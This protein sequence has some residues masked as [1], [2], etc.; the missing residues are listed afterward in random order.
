[1]LNEFESKRIKFGPA[2]AFL[3]QFGYGEVSMALIKRVLA[4][5]QCEVFT[6]L[7]YKDMNRWITDPNKAAAFSRAFGGNEW[8][9]CISLPEKQRREKL[10]QLYK[11]ALK[12]KGRAKY[13]VSFLMFD[14]NDAPLYW[15]LFCTN[16]LRGI[17]EMKKGMWKVDESG[18]FR[19]SDHD[20]PS[21]LMLLEKR[22]DQKW[23]AE[24]LK[25][26]LSG[27]TM[28]GE[29]IREFVLIETPCYLFK[30]ALKSLESSGIAKVVKEPTGR[31]PGT[32]ESLDGITL[33]FENQLFAFAE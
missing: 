30:A 16:S 2:L 27:Q 25:G 17:E 21:Q 8:N 28:N 11:D 23:L 7:D 24:E 20:D 6:Y 9:E 13:V 5:P 22:F 19:F 1:M 4:F 26:K 12:N 32:Y 15:L 29:K 18:E 14:R 3:D 33:R 10:L 31:R